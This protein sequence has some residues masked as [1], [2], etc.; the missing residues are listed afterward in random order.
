[1]REFNIGDIDKEEFKDV[2]KVEFKEISHQEN[3]TVRG[4]LRFSGGDAEQQQEHQ[5]S[6]D[7]K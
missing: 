2:D 1:M 6:A 5:E 7:N 4:L 3:P